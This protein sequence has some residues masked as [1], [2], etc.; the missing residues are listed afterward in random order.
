MNITDSVVMASNEM[1][2]GVSASTSFF[3]VTIEVY[4]YMINETE[5]SNHIV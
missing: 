4:L 5:G 1:S 2:L 3:Y